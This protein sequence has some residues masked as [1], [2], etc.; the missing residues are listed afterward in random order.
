MDK[1]AGFGNVLGARVTGV[2]VQ[3]HET[4]RWFRVAYVMPSGTLHECF[5]F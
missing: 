4:H 3:V 2:I 1:S 5:K